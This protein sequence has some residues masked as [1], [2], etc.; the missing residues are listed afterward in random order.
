[1]GTYD[2]NSTPST[3]SSMLVSFAHVYVIYSLGPTRPVCRGIG[4]MEPLM[5][6]ARFGFGMLVA[7]QWF[8][9][10]EYRVWR[11]IHGLW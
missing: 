6:E 1:M 2:S 7:A 3:N 5:K 11:A 9:F 10:A 4:T 8:E